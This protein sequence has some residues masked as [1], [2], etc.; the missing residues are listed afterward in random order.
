GLMLGVLVSTG[1]LFSLLRRPRLLSAVAFAVSLAAA[2]Y[3]QLY[4]V[5]VGIVQGLFVLGL[6]VSRSGSA[7]TRR[8]AWLVLAGLVAAAT[9]VRR[10]ELYARF[11]FYL[12]PFLLTALAAGG[13]ALAAVL[14][15]WLPMRLRPLAW[16]PIALG[17][18]ILLWSWATVFADFQID[19]GFR[20]GVRAL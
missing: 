8:G 6:L 10:A 2:A 14:A 13:A 19:E 15:R 3:F 17:A 5:P 4:A 18:A 12:A 20:D 7:A 11:F 9:L 16:G 1:L